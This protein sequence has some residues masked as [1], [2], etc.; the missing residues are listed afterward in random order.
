M[1]KKKKKGTE[2]KWLA[3]A[4]KKGEK[5]NIDLPAFPGSYNST[6]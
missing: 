3:E 5:I 1:N 4:R 2:I 6:R